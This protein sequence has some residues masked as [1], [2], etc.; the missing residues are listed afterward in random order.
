MHGVVQKSLL[1]EG[2]LVPLCLASL[3]HKNPQRCNIIVH[4]MHP[5][6]GRIKPVCEISVSVS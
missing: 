2:I 4:G 1:H 6:F 3:M 5:I